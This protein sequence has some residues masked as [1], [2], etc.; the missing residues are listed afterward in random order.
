[1]KKL[2]GYILHES[3]KGKALR[4][5]DRTFSIQTHG[6]VH[7]MLIQQFFNFFHNS[8]PYFFWGGQSYYNFPD[9]N[10]SSGLFLLHG[11]P[12]PAS[13]AAAPRNPACPIF[14][15]KRGPH[16]LN[17]FPKE[18]MAD[19]LSGAAGHRKKAAF[20]L[21]KKKIVARCVKKS[22][23]GKNRRKLLSASFLRTRTII[24]RLKKNGHGAEKITP[25]PFFVICGCRNPACITR[26]CDKCLRLLSGLRL[27]RAESGF[28][29]GAIPRK[30][31]HRR[32]N[33][34]YAAVRKWSCRT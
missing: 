10:K 30:Q 20:S 4:N 2:F 31:T 15:K 5:P 3:G 16:F 27:Q 1:M 22:E 26:A 34:L 24:F 13:T 33:P 7:S 11:L 14:A 8:L 32:Y 18:R 25:C 23:I 21:S 6:S 28:S 29:I 12:F 19:A 9:K 17:V